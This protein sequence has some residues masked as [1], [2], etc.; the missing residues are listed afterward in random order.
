MNQWNYYYVF[1]SKS[2]Q[3]YILHGNKLQFLVGASNLI[4][5][6]PTKVIPAV[7]DSMGLQA[8]TDYQILSASA[9]S[10]RI[11]FASKASA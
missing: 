1:S 8:D 2:L 5:G 10:T 9:G 6:I 4:E 3:K 11:L 7:L